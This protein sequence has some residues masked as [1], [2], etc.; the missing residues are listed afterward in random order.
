MTDERAPATSG[1]TNIAPVKFVCR[2]DIEI[3]SNFYYDIYKGRDKNMARVEQIE[4]EIQKLNRNDLATF[5]NW[6]RKYDANEWD[7]QIEEDIQT[8]KLDKLTEKA[9]AAHK[10]G[11]TKEF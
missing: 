2:L 10:A 5:R 6:F 4:Y 11:R 8:G 3:L 1:T 9:F 7:Q